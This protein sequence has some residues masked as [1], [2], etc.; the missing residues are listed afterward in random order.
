MPFFRFC[1]SIIIFLSGHGQGS[2]PKRGVV[3][4]DHAT[5]DPG[6]ATAR[7]GSCRE[8]P[9]I[10]MGIVRLQKTKLPGT[11]SPSASRILRSLALLVLRPVAYDCADVYR[12]KTVRA[13]LAD[14]RCRS[15]CDNETPG[16]SPCHTANP[17]STGIPDTF[18]TTSGYYSCNRCLGTGGLSRQLCR[19]GWDAGDNAAGNR[20]R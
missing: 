7:K 6:G 18:F 9:F 19:A 4:M 17:H 8:T 1:E 20:R 14:N 15:E 2:C 5:S 13:E 12:Q 16:K 11:T 10:C 3:R